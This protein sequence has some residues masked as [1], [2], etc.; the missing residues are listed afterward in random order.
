MSLCK[1]SLFFLGIGAVW[2]QKIKSLFKPSVHWPD[3]LPQLD[4]LAQQPGQKGGLKTAAGRVG[5][6]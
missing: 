3:A 2:L 5:A 4:Q 6:R 1:N